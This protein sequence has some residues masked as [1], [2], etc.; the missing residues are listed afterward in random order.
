MIACDTGVCPTAERLTLAEAEADRTAKTIPLSWL[1]TRSVKR[2]SNVSTGSAARFPFVT[3]NVTAVGA[4]D[5]SRIAA[6]ALNNPIIYSRVATGVSI[7][8]ML[9]DFGPHLQ[10]DR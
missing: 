8:Q 5:D 9:L 4:E 6:G 1:E 10:A 3:G 7:N 2:R